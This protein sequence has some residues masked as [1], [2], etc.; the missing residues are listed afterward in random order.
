MIVT[1]AFRTTTKD[2]AIRLAS[3]SSCII[4]RLDAKGDKEAWSGSCDIIRRLDERNASK[5]RKAYMTFCI[6]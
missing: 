6:Q 1:I 4:R 2:A 5:V 3:L